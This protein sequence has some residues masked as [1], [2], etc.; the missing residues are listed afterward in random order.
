MKFLIAALIAC[1]VFALSMASAETSENQNLESTGFK[2]LERNDSFSKIQFRSEK[3][4]VISKTKFSSIE[5]A[6]SFCRDHKLQLQKDGIDT[7]LL[8]AMSGAAN[9]DSELKSAISIGDIGIW[10]WQGSEDALL[11][12][13]NGRG[14]STELV[15]A[16]PI[17]EALGKTGQPSEIAAAICVEE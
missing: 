7:A 5:E 12:I 6:K 4:I 14:T 3:P 17:R 9:L 10:A 1:P 11:L 16:A 13:E 15:A 8:I 2:I